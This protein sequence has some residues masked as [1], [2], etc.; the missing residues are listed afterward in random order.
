MTSGPYRDDP[1]I[2]KLVTDVTR[3]VSTLVTKEIQ[4]AKSELKV[5]LTNA[6][7]GAG[8]FGAAAFLSLLAVVMLSISLAYFLVLAGLGPHWA[9]LIVTGGYLL[10]AALLGFVGYHKVRKVKGPERAI[11]QAQEIP[12]AFTPN[13]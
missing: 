5:S 12:K 7:T 6:G 2:G 4:L 11:A 3:D 10:I 8:L 9:F 13:R 1:T